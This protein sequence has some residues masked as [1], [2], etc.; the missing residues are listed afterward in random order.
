MTENHK[1]EIYYIDMPHPT[2]SRD[3]RE[4]WKE[5]HTYDS[6][7][8]DVVLKYSYVKQLLTKLPKKESVTSTEIDNLDFDRIFAK[9]NDYTRNPYSS[10]NDVGQKTLKRLKVRHTSMSVGDMLKI[11]NI[12]F[13][14][15]NR[16][17]KI[18]KFGRW[19]K[20]KKQKEN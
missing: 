18:V 2:M 7:D 17:F 11:N 5:L 16:G 9:Y 20:W 10:D 13:V 15:A 8:R 12:F 6:S 14:V 1:A 3:A 19:L 4:L